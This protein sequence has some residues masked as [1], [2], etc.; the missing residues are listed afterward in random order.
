MKKLLKENIVIYYKMN[1]TMNT[2]VDKYLY[3][4]VASIVIDWLSGDKKHWRIIKTDVLLRELKHMIYYCDTYKWIERYSTFNRD[5]SCHN[6]EICK[7]CSK[8]NR[9][10]K[11]INNFHNNIDL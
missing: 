5:C 6:F 9:F 1:N 3:P 2:V 11:L 4:D 7:I 10:Y 8:Y